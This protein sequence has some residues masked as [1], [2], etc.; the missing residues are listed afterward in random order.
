MALLR[1]HLFACPGRAE[2]VDPIKP[3]IESAWD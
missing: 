1:S 2:Q 3:T